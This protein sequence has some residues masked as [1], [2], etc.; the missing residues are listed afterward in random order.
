M[1]ER[2]VSA[3]IYT[4]SVL[5]IGI[6]GFVKGFQ[7]VQIAK[8]SITTLFFLSSFLFVLKTKC[9][10]QKEY[11]RYQGMVGIWHIL[12]LSLLMLFGG[13]KVCQFWML[14]SIAI[15]V[16]VSPY[17][18]IAFQC[19]FG[20]LYCLL[21]NSNVDYFVL[22]VALGAGICLMKNCF[23]RRTALAY[24]TL[25]SLAGNMIVQVLLKNFQRRE[26]FSWDTV[27]TLLSLELIILLVATVNWIYT[28][29]RVHNSFTFLKG[30]FKAFLVIEGTRSKSRE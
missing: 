12:S 10:S 14:G 18:G 5:I 23:K 2:I 24:V 17:F 13:I 15:G 6:G 7:A 16:M 25:I 9:N 26:I 19:L 8:L 1:K 3:M 30:G 28:G 11:K 27:L 22:Y 4:A 21:Q 29:Y 20:Y